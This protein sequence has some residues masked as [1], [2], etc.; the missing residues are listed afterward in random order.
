MDEAASASTIA[1]AVRSGSITATEVVEGALRRAHA[2]GRATNA[3]ITIA[4]DRALAC[5]A[6]LDRRAAEVGATGLGPLAGVP[7]V[8]KDNICVA[9]VRAT[10]GSRILDGFVPPYDATVVAR[11]EA[12][13][14]VVVAKANLDEFGMGSTNEN[15]GYGPV[16][17]PSAPERVPGGSSGGS[18]V[19]VAAGV[20]PLALGSDT[21]GSVRLPAS[22]CGVVGFKPTYGALSRYGLIAYASSLD[23]VGV[24]ARDTGDV[25]LAVRVMAGVDVRDATSFDLSMRRDDGQDTTATLAGLRVGVVRE[26]AGEGMQQDALAA[27]ARARSWLER[28]GA[29]VVEVALPSVRYAVAAYYVIATAEASSNLARYDG[30]LYGAR[31]GS[32]ADGQEA[33]MTRTRGKLLGRE[34][35]RRVLMG[36]FALSSGYYDA[37]YGRASK[38]RRKISEEMRGAFGDVD[39]LLSPT[40]TGVAYRAGEKLDDPIAMYVGDVAT[41]LA[42]LAG[43]PAVSV[44]MGTGEHGL[45]VGA[46]L[47]AAAGA[48]AHLLAVAAAMEAAGA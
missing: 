45:P 12:A 6:E 41:C 44:P 17:H 2:V 16:R 28:H 19:A 29:E 18:A 13:G 26:L 32:D 5:A 35:R 40:A 1:A 14:A 34:V 15:S 47:M 11:L 10:A 9:G 42:N 20:A 3:F 7:V 8:V 21:G 4:D 37:Y 46:Q 33:V 23:Q 31:R 36:S 48:D 27:L 24:L 22:F 43:V 30:M 39:V 25:A 38:V